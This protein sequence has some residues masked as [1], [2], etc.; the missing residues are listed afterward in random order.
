MKTSLCSLRVPWVPGSACDERHTINVGAAVANVTILYDDEPPGAAD[1]EWNP[2]DVSYI[3]PPFNPVPGANSQVFSV[4]VQQ[5]GKSVLGG[6]FD[7]VNATPRNH[8]ARLNV[9]GSLDTNFVAFPNNGA[10]AFVSKVIVL[11]DNRILIAGGFSSY[12]GYLRNCIARLLPDGRLDPS[13]APGSGANGAIWDMVLQ[14]NGQI[15]IAGDFTRYNGTDRYH[16]ARL[17][18]DGSLDASFDSGIGSDAPILALALDNGQQGQQK[19]YIGGRFTSYRDTLRSHFARVNADGT[20]DDTFDPGRGPD[21][22]V[23]ALAVQSDTRILLG[24]SFNEYNSKGRRNIAR[25]NA[26]GSLDA[27]FDP[28]KGAD[29]AV[30]AITL[31]PDGRPYLGGIFTSYNSTR[32]TGLAMLRPDGKL[33]TSFMDTGYNQFAG[34]IKKYNFEPNNLVNTIALQTDGNLMIGGSFT[35]LGGN[36]PVALNN[37]TAPGYDPGG[38][39]DNAWTRQDKVR[40]YNVARLI[41]TWGTGNPTQ[42][43]GN[44][45]FRL[46]AYSVDENQPVMSVQ[47]DRLDGLLGTAGAMT[48]T[49][50][51][52]AIAGVDYVGTTAPTTFAEWYGFMVSDGFGGGYPLVRYFNVPIIDNSRIDGNRILD[53]GLAEPFGRMTGL[54]GEFVPLGGALG[55]S[56]STLTIVDNDFSPGT[57]VFNPTNYLVSENVAGTTNVTLTVLRTNGLHGLVTVDYW[58]IDGTARAGQDYLYVSNRLTFFSGIASQTISVPILH[59]GRVSDD[60]TFTVVMTN[61]T[62]GALLPGGT[63]TSTTR[64]EVSI[65]DVDYPSGRLNFMPTNYLADEYGGSVVLTVTRTGGNAGP[66]YASVV[67]QDG[68]GPDAA[69]AGLN[70]FYTSNYLTWVNGDT[71]PQTV[72]IPIINDLAANPDRNF[73]ARL[74]PRTGHL[75]DVGGRSNAFVT[76]VN[77]DFPGAFS[78]SSA[79][80]PRG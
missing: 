68:I 51:R 24:G 7:A 77:D 75:L 55:R 60:L 49:S 54:G 36:N 53:L 74:L 1:R 66:I 32:R 50:N 13:F 22:P 29:G 40:R 44:V 80:I 12:D 14:A 35:N 46:A 70:Y 38:R 47:M 56:Y 48:Y 61:A 15:V 27:E 45:E 3:T 52:I 59:N 25:A 30:Y 65:I 5:D 76:I 6:D 19:I 18:G 72:T 11:N 71:T 16:L 23:Y 69:I 42:G 31:R 20:L 63:P 21:G 39:Y 37:S 28:G 79:Q 41:G 26:D 62:G 34:V 43:P 78:F 9:D 67:T 57:L 17:N 64:A 2:A 4:A 73:T 10:D 33:D 8:I 58:T